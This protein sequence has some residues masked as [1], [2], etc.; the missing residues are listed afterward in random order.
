MLLG[1]LF[2]IFVVC[3]LVMV[4]FECFFWCLQVLGF[5]LCESGDYYGYSFVLGSVDVML[6]NLVNVYCVLVNQGC[7]MFLCMWFDEVCM[8]VCVMQVMDVDVVYIVGD[9]FFDCSVCVCI[10]GLENVLFICI[11]MV[12]KIGILKDMCDN[13]CVGYF[14][15][16]IVGV[17]VGNVF[18]VLMWDVFGVIGVVLVWQ[19]VM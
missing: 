12:V 4:M 14:L 2:N 13:W 9:I 1:F 7:Y 18:G 11:W 10:F 6:V 19:E 15:C 17:W 8:L 5:N 16:Y 3:M